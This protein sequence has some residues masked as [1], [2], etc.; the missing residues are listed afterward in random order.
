LKTLIKYILQRVLGLDNYLFL[1]SLFIIKKLRWDKNE[2]DFIHF[3][4]LLPREGIVL[5]IG[6]N[7][8]VMSYYLARGQKQRKIFAFEPIP[9]NFRNLERIKRKYS[10]N[11]LEIFQLALGDQNGTI[12][13]VLPV[14]RSVRFHGLAHVKDENMPDR[15]DIFQCPMKR[16]DEVES[17]MQCNSRVT[18]IKIDVENYEYFVLKGATGL[19]KKHRPVIYCELWDNDNRKQTM[20]LLTELGYRTLVLKNNLL[21]DYDP[22]IH[23][24]QNFFFL[25]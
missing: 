9:I 21:V 5:D 1:F 12:D 14:Q 25:S 20:K 10:L 4:N 17:I 6:A 15:G 16:L 3:L 7:I 18:G 8:G 23:S 19:I 11:N 13:M 22:D 2:K 24:T